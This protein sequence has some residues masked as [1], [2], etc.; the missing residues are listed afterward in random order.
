MNEAAKI[1]LWFDRFSS[2]EE[3]LDILKKSL[4]LNCNI[5][6]VGIKY[7]TEVG[8]LIL[9]NFEQISDFNFENLEENSTVFYSNKKYKLPSTSLR[10]KFK[11]ITLI[12]ENGNREYVKLGDFK[13][14][15]EMKKV[16]ENF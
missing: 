15:E 10:I 16:F 4:Q 7:N 12:D 6:I 1:T 3:H 11:E 2:V 9:N 13:L 8:K 5:N 14:E